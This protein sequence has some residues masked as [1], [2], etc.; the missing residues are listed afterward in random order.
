[1]TAEIARNVA[2]TAGAADQM[3]TSVAEV[4]TNAEEAACHAVEVHDTATGLTQA[5]GQLKHGVIRAVRN[6]TDEVNRRLNDRQ[7]LERNCQVSIPGQKAHAARV[8]D[9]S[10]GGACVRD[11]PNLRVGAHGTLAIDGL[12]TPLPFDVRCAD[13]QGLHLKFDLNDKEAACL[14]VMLATLGQGAAA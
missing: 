4:A 10:A 1:M 9:I 8:T 3:T 13:Q 5:V 6:S 14:Q 2:L 12:T 11:G 7:N